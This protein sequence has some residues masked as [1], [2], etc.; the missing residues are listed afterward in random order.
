MNFFG[1]Y[2]SG[3]ISSRILSDIPTARA[4]ISGNL[5]HLITSVLTAIFNVVIL[6]NLNWKLATVILIMFPIY[7]LVIEWQR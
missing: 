1:K 4:A 6:I 3:E 7:T 2:K 5:N